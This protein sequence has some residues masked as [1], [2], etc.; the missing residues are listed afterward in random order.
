MM[1]LF[2][3]IILGI[4]IITGLKKSKYN[5]S[6][7]KKESGN[8]YFS[9]MMDKGKYGEY[10]SFNILEKIKGEHRI[11]T[12]VYLPKENEETTEVDLVYI[13]ETGI[14]VLE[15]K[16]YSGWIFGDEKSKNWM[17][18]LQNGQKEKF[19]NPI[20]QNKT[21]IKYLMRLLNIDES[22]IKSI[23]VF[24]DR[25]TLKKLDVKSE[26]V[27]VINRYNLNKTI[28]KLIHNS[29]KILEEG[30]IIELYYELK[31]YTHASDEIKLKHID[32][33]NVIKNSKVERNNI[34]S[35]KQDSVDEE[36]VRENNP[37]YQ[38]ITYNN[39]VIEEQNQ[40]NQIYEEINDRNPM[41]KELKEYRLNKSREQKVKP[42]FIYSNAEL[43]EIIRVKPKTIDELKV[44]HGFGSVKCDKYGVDIINVVTKYC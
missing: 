10:L 26:N 34:K 28:E 1:E 23:I 3:I 38:E 17:Q 12:N 25:C 35:E 8:S 43:E 40:N 13:H 36:I 30:K 29:P 11:L 16:N 20:W 21:H 14:Y 24:S 37:I 5:K 9:V 41:Y 7:Y 22:F 27:K 2:I 6:N 31:P 19:Y 44:I 18:T 39:V 4:I 32:N 33:I 42:Y 15:S